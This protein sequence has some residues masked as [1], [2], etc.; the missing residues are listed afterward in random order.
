LVAATGVLEV[1]EHSVDGVTTRRQK[2][3]ADSLELL[4][5]GL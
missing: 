1:D 5:F 3:I 2:G 4:D